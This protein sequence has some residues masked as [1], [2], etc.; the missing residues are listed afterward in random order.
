VRDTITVALSDPID[1]GHAPVPR[2]E[3]ERWL[4]AQLYETLIR[5][6]CR[7][8]PLPGLARSWESAAGS[9]WTFTLRDDA[10]FWD[11]APVTARD[12][13]GA[14]RGRDST[15]ARSVTIIG[16]RVFSVAAPDEALQPFAEPALA[17][18]KPA[19]G[20][21][22]IGTGAHWV[23]GGDTGAP[24][25]LWARPVPGA[26]LPALRLIMVLTP[27]GVRDA[28]DAGADIVLTGDGAALEY[29]GTSPAYLD[30]PLEWTRTYVL[31]AAAQRTPGVGDI[32]LESLRQALHLDVRP[33]ELDGGE[34]PWFTDLAACPSPP[35]LT[36]GADRRRGDWIARP[37]VVYDRTDGSA[38]DLAARLIGLGVLG[39]AAVAAGFV[40]DAF[41]SALRAGGDAAYVV[42]LPRRV[43]DPCRA[44]RELPAWVFTGTVTPLLD[45]RAHAVVRRSAPRLRI[46]W[47]GTP[48]F[49][50]P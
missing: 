20:G 30:I 17:V 32:R 22:P 37:H 33:A 34:R 27:A 10:R 40:P 42:S 43:Y 49:T 11:G 48:R 5:V 44:A 1:P 8:R 19:P 47:D 35:P 26:S 6:D 24:D 28:L 18:T 39:P 7:G 2:T 13:V 25:E 23:T 50:T 31:L 14:W 3:A 12:V 4:F 21:W 38:A 29:A 15:L 46:D 9:R 45:V 41:T 16:D 36:K